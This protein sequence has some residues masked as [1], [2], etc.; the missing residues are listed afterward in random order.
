MRL[1]IALA[2]SLLVTPAFS[3]SQTYRDR[4]GH[5]AGSS[6]TH[7]NS[8]TFYDR[9]GHYQGSTITRGK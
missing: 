3:Q 9:N 1:T 4:N 5:Y 2:L 6:Q 7:G 8:T